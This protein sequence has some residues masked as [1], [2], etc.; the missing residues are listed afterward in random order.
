M[1]SPDRLLR[2]SRSRWREHEPDAG[3]F[4]D[5]GHSRARARVQHPSRWTTEKLAGGYSSCWPAGRRSLLG[6]EC[7]LVCDRHR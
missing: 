5:A 6:L 3:M 2:T 7:E 4:C 1:R